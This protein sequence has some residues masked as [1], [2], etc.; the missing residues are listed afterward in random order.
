MARRQPRRAA[1]VELAQRVRRAVRQAAGEV[2]P[3]QPVSTSVGVATYPGDA[4]DP[5]DLM[6]NADAALYAAKRAGRN[7]VVPFAEVADG[8]AV[9]TVPE[10]H[11]AP[12]RA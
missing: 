3:E 1:A 11:G 7:L 6:R 5:A 9:G 4:A 10:R 8:E 2:V 12:T